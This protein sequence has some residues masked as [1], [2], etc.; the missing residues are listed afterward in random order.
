[1]SKW[2][3][4]VQ[5]AISRNRRTCSYIS[6]SKAGYNP[7]TGTNTVTETTT[8]FDAARDTS[9]RS[10]MQGTSVILVDKTIFYIA[11]NSSFTPK[12]NDVIQDG[13]DKYTI[14]KVEKHYAGG[15]LV[16]YMVYCNS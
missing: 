14:D 1:M 9:R 3:D 8:S 15:E 16:M 6:K 10:Q 12:A 7:D 5:R 13:T 4:S 11:G 2:L